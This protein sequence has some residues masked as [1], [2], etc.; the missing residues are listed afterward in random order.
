MLA[1]AYKVVEMADGESVNQ[2]T[3]WWEELTGRGGEGNHR[4]DACVGWRG[5]VNRG[6]QRFGATC[7]RQPCTDRCRFRAGR[8]ANHGVGWKGIGAAS[9]EKNQMD[10]FALL[11]RLQDFVKMHGMIVYIVFTVQSRIDR[12]QEILGSDLQAMAAVIEQRNVG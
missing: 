2:A 10:A 9:I 6:R 4:A 7:L 5:P 3:A 11:L 1:T 12:D 8:G